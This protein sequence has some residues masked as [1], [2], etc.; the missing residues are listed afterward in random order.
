MVNFGEVRRA[1]LVKSTLL[2][3]TCSW[4]LYK[5]FKVC[6]DAKENGVRKDTGSYRTYLIPGKTAAL[7]RTFA[8]EDLPSAEHSDDGVGGDDD[9]I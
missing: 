9:D 5:S 6:L 4:D 2:A 8:V 3:S 7:V 1:Q